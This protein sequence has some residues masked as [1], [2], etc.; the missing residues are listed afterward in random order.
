MNE[1]IDYKGRLDRIAEGIKEMLNERIDYLRRLDRIAEI[2][3]NVDHRC[4]A[5]DGPVTHTLDEM[6]QK[7]ISEI[8]LHAKEIGYPNRWGPELDNSPCGSCG[9]NT[10]G[11]IMNSDQCHDVGCDG[12]FSAWTPPEDVEDD[13]GVIHDQ[14]AY[15]GTRCDHC[16]KVDVAVVWHLGKRWCKDCYLTVQETPEDVDDRQL[17]K[18][19]L[20][21][22]PLDGAPPTEDRY[23]EDVDP[24]HNPRRD[25]GEYHPPPTGQ[26]APPPAEE[27]HEDVETLADLGESPET[28]IMSGLTPKSRVKD[29][30]DV[31]LE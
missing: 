11:D 7:E 5:A 27:T 10:V 14:M 2:I 30:E 3:E 9:H 23:P 31:E 13:P 18:L 28:T 4:Q 29:S 25:R 26:L 20:P 19:D 24:P 22:E 16:K 1:K 15:R 8:Y 17:V 21:G 6:T 12:N